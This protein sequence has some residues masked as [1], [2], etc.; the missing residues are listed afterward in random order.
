LGPEQGQVF[1]G[2]VRA[3]LQ[4]G[5]QLGFPTANLEPSPEEAVHLP[6]G[7]FAARVHRP[8]AGAHWAVVNIGQRP[9][10]GEGMLSVEAHLLDF[11]GDLYG[12]VLE[13]EL[14][15]F[16]R[17]ERRFAE[18]SELVAQVAQDVELARNYIDN[19]TAID[20]TEV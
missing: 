8:G 1:S 7:V 19:K 20:T 3:G 17:P 5:R 10:F 9:T 15:R 16:L 11:D 4:R 2:V 18:V 14:M 13:V 12:Q 6:R